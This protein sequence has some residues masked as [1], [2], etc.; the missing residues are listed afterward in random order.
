MWDVDVEYIVESIE[1][2]KGAM[3][4]SLEEFKSMGLAKDGIYKR[5]EFAIQALLDSLSGLGRKRG[6]I[7][8]SYSDL[9]KSLEEKGILPKET[10]EKA[11]F[12][13]QLRE[14]LIYDYDLMNDEIA[15]RNM[16]E[17]IEY[18]EELLRFLRGVEG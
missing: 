13:A 8:L 14:V 12:L 7:A 15:F 2:I 1:L 11:E 16:E 17:Y 9:I 6:I 5:L 18:V 10:A 3:P 4:D